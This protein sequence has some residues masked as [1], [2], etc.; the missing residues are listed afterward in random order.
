MPQAL[1]TAL[2]PHALKVKQKRCSAIMN[3]KIE[4]AVEKTKPTTMTYG[5][6]VA[7]EKDS[8]C[9]EMSGH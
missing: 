7:F 1:S 2:K 8:A 6:F 9:V 4:L 3:R 5:P